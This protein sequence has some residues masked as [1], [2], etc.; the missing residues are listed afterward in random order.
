MQRIEVVW[1]DD[2]HAGVKEVRL[3][4][5]ATKWRTREGISL[6]STLKE[7]ERLNGSPFR[8]VGFAFDYSGTITDCE[9]GQ[10]G[11]LG[12]ARTVRLLILRLAPSDEARRR[13][14]YGEVLG[15][16]DFSSSNPAMQALNPSVYQMVVLL[17]Q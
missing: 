3:T 11:V 7:I 10:L 6:G 15:D 2:S 16:R 12:S 8:L 4:G 14:E 5:N 17:A 9:G 13:P 1:R